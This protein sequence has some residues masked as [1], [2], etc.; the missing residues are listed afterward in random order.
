[1]RPIVAGSPEDERKFT[2]VNDELAYNLTLHEGSVEQMVNQF[3][4]V[5]PGRMDVVA[6]WR[7]VA[8]HPDVPATL[9]LLRN[10]G[11]SNDERRDAMVDLREAVNEATGED[12]AWGPNPDEV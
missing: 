11:I 8:L 4:S 2:E 10:D 5:L 9:A 7:T 3:V 6:R 1:M 12:R